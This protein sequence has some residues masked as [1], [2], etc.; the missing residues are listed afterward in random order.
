LNRHIDALGR[1][2]DP[3]LEDASQQLEGGI[4]RIDAALPVL[5]HL[6]RRLYKRFS[7]KFFSRPRRHQKR[8]AAPS[9]VAVL[10]VQQKLKLFELFYASSD[11]LRQVLDEL[12]A[13]FD[14][15]DSSG[16]LGRLRA[17]RS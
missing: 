12:S 2:F 7:R 13:M 15:S 5:A 17:L 16:L 8:L 6:D 10:N 4:V 3:R 11:H 1:K 9:F 14:E